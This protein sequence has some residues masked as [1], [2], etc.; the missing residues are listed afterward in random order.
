MRL[1]VRYV[2]KC[3]LIILPRTLENIALKKEKGRKFFA[4]LKSLIS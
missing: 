2:A 3:S 4:S 1:D